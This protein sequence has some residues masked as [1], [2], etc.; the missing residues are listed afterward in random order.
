MRAIGRPVPVLVLGTQNRLGFFNLFHQPRA[1]PIKGQ[2]DAHFALLV[3]RWK[4]IS[5]LFYSED[6]AEHGRVRRHASS[7]RVTVSTSEFWSKRSLSETHS[8]W[9]PSS[10]QFRR[11]IG[12]ADVF[13]MSCFGDSETCDGT[14]ASYREICKGGTALYAEIY[15]LQMESITIACDLDGRHSIW[16]Q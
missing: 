15:I 10:S 5:E 3:F 11:I 13:G 7:E 12:L 14:T 1:L 6:T 2:R 8:G 16:L 4:I 9:L